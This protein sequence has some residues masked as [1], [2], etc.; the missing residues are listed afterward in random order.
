MPYDQ[1]TRDK[2]NGDMFMEFEEAEISFAPTFKV[3]DEPGTV[4]LDEPSK[5]R[6]PSWCDRVLWKS[7]P[8]QRQNLCCGLFTSFPQVSTSDH[9][10]VC[11]YFEVFPSHS[12]QMADAL[13]HEE[14]HKA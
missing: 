14:S 3:K 10:P 6:V 5:L 8:C 1:L 11:A 12:P 4:Y 13:P 2:G 9:K 7:L